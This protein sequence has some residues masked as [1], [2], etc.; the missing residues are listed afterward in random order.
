MIIKDSVIIITGATAG[1]GLAIAKNLAESK[2]KLVLSGRR[3]DRLEALKQE[4]NCPQERVLLAA[5]DIRDESFCHHLIEQTVA[6]FGRIDVLI[7]N[8]G[9]GHNS[10]LVNISSEDFKQIWETNLYGLSW[11]SQAAAKIMQSQEAESHTGRCG[12]IIN[13]SSIIGNRPLIGQGIY[14]ASKAA[15]NAYSRGLRME[16]AS[17]K[18]TVSL[19]YPGQTL[20]EFHSAK[21]GPKSRRNSRKIG[22][23]STDVAHT[24]KRAI[25]KQKIDVYITFYG[26]LFVQAN[27]WFPMLTDQIFKHIVTGDAD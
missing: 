16:L 27:R 5:G 8:A 25:I 2:A 3:K 14:T 7:N 22:A 10:S 6:T 23:L 21:L 11:L 9:L 18:I 12:Q 20:T 24:I 19:V 4:L 26:W 1:I 13:V 15:V 17:S